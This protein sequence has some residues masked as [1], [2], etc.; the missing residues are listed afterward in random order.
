MEVQDFETYARITIHL[1]GKGISIRDRVPGSQIG[2]KRQFIAK[3]KQLVLSKI[4]A[5]NGAFGVLSE[6]CDR[7]IITGNFWAFEVNHER[8]NVDYFDYLT[9]TPLFIDFCVR[10]SEGTTNRRYLQEPKFLAQEIPL[11][12]LDEQRR[13]VGRIEALAAKIEQV[14]TLRE[15][16]SR[17]ADDLIA[18]EEMR[19]WPKRDL[20]KAETLGNVTS[21]LA[22][23]RQSQQ[24]N[25]DHYLIKT[26]H[27]QLGRYVPT[28]MT[29]APHVASKV[30]PEAMVQTGD[31]LIA[32]SA[33][34]C[35]GRVAFYFDG[36]RKA[37]TDTHVAIARAKAGVVLP[38]Y[39]YSYLKGAQGQVQ[40]RSREK[41]DWQREKVGFRLTELNVADMR[42]VLIP[43]PP[44][45][46]QR[47]I[48][49]Y[50]DA[51]QAKVDALK[52]LQ[53]ETAAELGA[54]LPSI[55]DKA[56]RGDF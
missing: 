21:Y 10:A 48:V 19:I 47:R 30:N 27:V 44:T 34:G 46:D 32:C 14:R 53:T 8:L 37:S 49:A 29:L 13:I 7:A 9:K 23:G 39:L 22:R 45:S 26:Q 11:P 18:S 54:L 52:R 12:P 28:L 4:D 3:A 51:L 1:N 16:A 17:G 40:L 31:V 41:G 24:G 15:V 42:G 5:R 38:E 56:F 6:E 25:S 2:T 35:L 50:L 33:A 55:L 43:V 36:E 20:E